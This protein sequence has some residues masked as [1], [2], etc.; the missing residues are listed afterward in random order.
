MWQFLLQKDVTVNLWNFF[1][2]HKS[3]SWIPLNV[4]NLRRPDVQS[5]RD[6]LKRGFKSLFGND[7]WT[8]SWCQHDLPP[9]EMYFLGVAVGQGAWKAFIKSW[10]KMEWMEWI[11]VTRPWDCHNWDFSQDILGCYP[12]SNSH[13]QD[14]TVL[15]WDPYSPSHGK[16]ASQ[17]LR[18]WIFL[19]LMGPWN[20]AS[21]S[22][23]NSSLS[24]YL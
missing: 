12:P 1:Q 13:H 4:P 23:G 21:A 8:T 18:R 16:G 2:W 6:V 22:W 17:I 14:V 19:L 7:F 3:R 11:V 20:P 15:A 5:L 10:W 24:H 9:K